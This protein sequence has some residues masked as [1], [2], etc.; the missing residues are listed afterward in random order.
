MS[1]ITIIGTGTMARALGARA[2]AGGNAVEITG[3]DATKAADLA[4]WLGG[5]ATAGTFGAVPAGDIVIL[6]L[7]YQ[8]EESVVA[9]YGDALTGK[10]IIDPS[11]PLNSDLTGKVVPEGNEFDLIT[12]QSE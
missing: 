4:E 1:S 7:L 8:A 11:N 3:R 5:G 10:I 6:A 2:I 12:F 9:Q